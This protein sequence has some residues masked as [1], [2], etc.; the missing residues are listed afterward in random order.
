[1]GYYRDKLSLT[2]RRNRKYINVGIRLLYCR[3]VYMST[4]H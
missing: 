4:I 2:T 1:M 3:M